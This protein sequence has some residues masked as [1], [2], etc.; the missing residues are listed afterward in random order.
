MNDRIKAE[1]RAASGQ[2]NL[3]KLD[4]VRVGIIG[5]G[6]VGLPLAVYMA[7]RFPV[8]GFD[9]NKARVGELAKGRDRTGEVTDEEF[10][11]ARTIS[12][13]ADTEALRDCNFYIVTVPTPIDEA[14]RPDQ[15]TWN[16]GGRYDVELI[17]ESH[18]PSPSGSIATEGS[19]TGSSAG[20][21]WRRPSSS[22][23]KLS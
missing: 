1:T 20:T 9:V 6:Y 16:K 13:C 17:S 5:L 8:V 7:R 10:A 21:S 3:P 12:F 23:G 15:Q 14:K 2:G 18:A 19:S 22:R 4:N 11:A